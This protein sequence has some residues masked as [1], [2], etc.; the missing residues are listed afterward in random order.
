MSAEEHDRV[1]AATSHVPHIVAA[2]LASLLK[3]EQ[4]PLAAA[5]FRDTTRIA[6]GDPDLWTAILINNPQPVSDQLSRVLHRLGE[7]RDALDAADASA[8]RS[9]LENAK[10]NRDALDGVSP[11]E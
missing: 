8:I 6:A 9:F 4:F 1:V 3:S 5:G 2:G 10:A 7:I 11:T